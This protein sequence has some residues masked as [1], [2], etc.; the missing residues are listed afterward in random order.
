MSWK[1]GAILSPV[2]R[3]SAMLG[4]GLLMVTSVVLDLLHR[5]I[6]L[7]SCTGAPVVISPSYM[8]YA[9]SRELEIVLGWAVS[10]I[11]LGVVTIAWVLYFLIALIRN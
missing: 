11:G 2:I 10:C 5:T 6:P 9:A 4:F 3:M 1:I 8:A 7:Q